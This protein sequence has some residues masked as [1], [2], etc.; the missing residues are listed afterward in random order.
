MYSFTRRPLPASPIG[1][2]AHPSHPTPAPSHPA[3]PSARRPVLL[4]P[5]PRRPPLQEAHAARPS[6]RPTPLEYLE[7]W[8]EEDPPVPAPFLRRL[9]V[10]RT[11][12]SRLLSTYALPGGLDRGSPPSPTPFL[13]P[14]CSIRVR[15]G[16]T[17]LRPLKVEMKLQR[18]RK[19]HVR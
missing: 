1:A 7:D 19:S 15:I 12:G 18:S 17:K 6:T 4:G 2:A 11:E 5:P 14:P 10:L 8:T 3:P 9:E 13:R 16:R